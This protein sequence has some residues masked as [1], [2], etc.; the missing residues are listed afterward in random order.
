MG[1]RERAR[2]GGQA[3]A[4][5]GRRRPGLQ[6]QHTVGRRCRGRQRTGTRRWSSC[7]SRRT[8]STRTPRTDYGRTPLSWA[9]E[10]GHEAV[11]KLLLATGR[12]RPGLQ[13]QRRS[14]AAVVGRRERARG[15]GQAAARD[16]TASTRTPRT[17]TVGR[18]CRG[19]Q[20]TGTRRWSSCCSRQ[21]GVDPD[22]KDSDGRTP[23]SWAAENGHEAVVKL[24]L[25]T[26]RRRPGLQGQ[27]TVGR[28]C[29]GRQ[30]TGT[31]RWSSCCSRQDGVDPDSK[32]SYG[33]TPL[34]WAAE[35]GH[36]A[37]VKL[38]LATDGVDP[39]SKD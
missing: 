14:D 13:G 26:G 19:P 15:G 37:V 30:R 10:N 2:G 33:R 39:D 25:A 16:R 12:R 8:T 4:R 6:G 29:R 31:R 28:R 7:C 21:D 9:A 3:A 23:L 17:A 20:R 27:T 32:D 18:R 11:V 5:D 24:L 34:S 36:E 22:S 35:N 38:L 1:G